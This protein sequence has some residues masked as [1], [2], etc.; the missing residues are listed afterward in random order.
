MRSQARSARRRRATKSPT[1]ADGTRQSSTGGAATAARE[2]EGLQ[3]LVGD[4]VPTQ[5]KPVVFEVRVKKWKEKRTTWKELMT[6]YPER[7]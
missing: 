2:G 6:R 4:Y 7:W 3:T 1:G 5:H